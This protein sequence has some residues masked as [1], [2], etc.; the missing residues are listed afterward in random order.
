[1][2]K[3]MMQGGCRIVEVM[4]LNMQERNGSKC[5]GWFW[6]GRDLEIWITQDHRA[7]ENRQM[8]LRIS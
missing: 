8:P 5:R 1:M 4:S 7:W 6:K 2:K 3:S